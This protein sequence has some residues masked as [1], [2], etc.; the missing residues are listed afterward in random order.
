MNIWILAC[1]TGLR[2]EWFNGNPPTDTQMLLPQLRLEGGKHSLILTKEIDGSCQLIMGV[3]GKAGSV[4]AIN[5]LTEGQARRFLVSLLEQNLVFEEFSQAIDTTGEEALVDC[6][7]VEQVVAK[8]VDS[9]EVDDDAQ[10]MFPEWIR[11]NYQTTPDAFK[12]AAEC[13]RTRRFSVGSG[14]KIIIADHASFKDSSRADIILSA[15]SVRQDYK[16]GV[17][18]G[19]LMRRLSIVGLGLIA[20]VGFIAI[21][22]I[23]ALLK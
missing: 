11:E 14:T 2:P 20:A 7:A 5:E 15:I 13:L 23:R 22:K 8:L 19:V 4:L 3:P 6:K 1:G 10:P 16:V 18:E 9:S 12:A 21:R 17:I